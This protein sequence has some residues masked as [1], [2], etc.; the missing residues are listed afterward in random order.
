MNSPSPSLALSLS[1]L[2]LALTAEPTALS[3][4]CLATAPRVWVC[5]WREMWGRESWTLSVSLPSEVWMDVEYFILSS[6]AVCVL[7]RRM[8]WCL[9]VK[10]STE[11]VNKPW[12]ERG[13]WEKSGCCCYLDKKHLYGAY[14]ETY[15]AR[16]REVSF[17]FTA[18]IDI[19]N[20]INVLSDIIFLEYET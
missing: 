4:S 10:C 2:P 11:L 17:E 5:V 14:I 15:G 9:L 16:L 1:P 7:L 20:K 13:E 18:C 8:L 3:Y 6:L 19:P 12:T